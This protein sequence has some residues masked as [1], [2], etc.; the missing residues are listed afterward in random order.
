M[1]EAAGENNFRASPVWHPQGRRKGDPKHKCCGKKTVL[2]SSHI[3]EE[4]ERITEQIVILHSGRLL[5]IGNLHAIRD[6]LDKHPHRILIKCEDPR[7]LA[8]AFISEGPVFGVRFPREGELEIQTN[9]LSAA[10]SLLPSIVVDSKQR[11]TSI[12]NPDDNL[13]SLLNYLIK[14]AN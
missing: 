2:V 4:I 10:H 6:L 7:A 9:N 12:E 13:D 3:L 11:I 5:A 1:A 8:S 14:E